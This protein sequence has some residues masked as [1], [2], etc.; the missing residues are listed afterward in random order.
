MAAGGA[1]IN[2]Q[3]DVK[4]RPMQREGMKT[5]MMTS[6][7]N[8]AVGTSSGLGPQRQT[9]D[10]TYWIGI[11]RPKIT[12]LTQEVDRLRGV[13]DNITKNS[14][15]VVQMQQRQ[16]TLADEIQKLKT[17]MAD[18]N[19]AVE[20]YNTTEV[21]AISA[22]AQTMKTTNVELRKNVDKLF[23]QVK[24]TEDQ[25]AGVHKQLDELMVQLDAR[26][27]SDSQVYNEYH[28]T[29]EEMYRTADLLLQQQQEVRSLGRRQESLL[30]SLGQDV[31]KKRAALMVL[32][33]VKKR[34]MR[35]DMAREC[36]VSIEEERDQL[37]RQAKMTTHDI[38]VLQRQITEARDAVQDVRQRLQA[39]AEDLNEY[40]GE[41]MRKY[42]ELQEKD[43]EMQEFIDTF[44]EKE[45]EE[46]ERIRQTEETIQSFLQVISRAE[47]LKASLPPDNAPLVMD[48]MGSEIGEKEKQLEAARVTYQRLQKQLDEK[49]EELDK[50]QDLDSRI[51]H[52][53]QTM[54]QRI[55]EQQRE[56]VRFAD[57]EGLRREIETRKRTLTTSKGQLT[58]QRD[59]SKQHLHLLSQKFETLKSKLNESDVHQALSAQE[60]K[61][62]L[63]WQS[64]FSLDDFVRMKEKESNYTTLKADCLR[65]TDEVNGLL[66]ETKR[67]EAPATQSVGFTQQQGAW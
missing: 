53:I 33:V 29:R 39:G 1:G 49:K 8:R 43:R 45:R 67:T 26:L 22:Q 59:G 36:S 13:E 51:Q 41:N 4:A 32:D 65:M 63:V 47:Q 66:K 20:N 54:Q 7:G 35:D 60:Q 21:D 15:V 16:K 42:Q 37:V 50:V 52:D 11:L 38:D 10:R 64:V 58:K 19:F 12:E 48:Q 56:M 46:L 30:Q 9:Q 62:R 28:A 25:A 3:V 27:R 6:G 57:L 2:T 14:S 55:A 5:M 40:S 24:S 17:T 31:D 18:L 23:L 61:L 44:K 34:Q